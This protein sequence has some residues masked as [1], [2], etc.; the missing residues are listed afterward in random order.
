MLAHSKEEAVPTLAKMLMDIRS[1]GADF[2][3]VLWSG[4][5]RSDILITGDRSQPMP[6]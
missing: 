6:T 3:T 1:I 2:A 5:D 4:K